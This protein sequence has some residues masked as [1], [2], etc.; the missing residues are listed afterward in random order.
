MYLATKE[1]LGIF[2]LIP[3]SA[4]ISKIFRAAHKILRGPERESNR[5]T[6]AQIQNGTSL[7]I[8][9]PFKQFPTGDIGS[10]S[11]KNLRYP[12]DA[13][14]FVSGIRSDYLYKQ[15]NPAPVFLWSNDSQTWSTLNVIDK[16]LDGTDANQIDVMD[17]QSSQ[18]RC[19]GLTK[20]GQILESENGGQCWK[21]VS[22][23]QLPLGSKWK[24]L[25]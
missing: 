16:P 8:V 13:H 15:G 9:T 12:D 11:W 24:D 17:C 19:A 18:S 2:F 14:C 20:R 6:F 10:A 25:R 3:A 5:V 7:L 22:S 1:P 21:A 23:F 4:K